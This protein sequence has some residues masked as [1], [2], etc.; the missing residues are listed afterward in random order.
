MGKIAELV[1]KHSNY[2]K[3]TLNLIPSENIMTPSSRHL[4]CSDLVHRY[5]NPHNVYGGTKYSDAIVEET[6]KIAQKIFKS[7]FAFVEPLSGNI[8]VL[9]AIYA[10]TNIGD[11]VMI[12]SPDDGGYP[13]NLEKLGRKPVYFPFDKGKMNIDFLKAEKLILKEK[14]K[15]IIFGQSLF[16]FPHPV[17]ELSETAKEVEA[18]V[19]YDGSHVLGL[20][21]GGV[22]QDPLREGAQI[23]LGS[24]HKTFPGPQGGIIVGI[25]ET[26]EQKLWEALGFPLVLVDNPHLHRIAA[27]GATL[28]EYE[29]YGSNYAKQVVKNAKTLA[30][31]LYNGGLNVACAELGF[32]ESHQV[33]LLTDSLEEGRKMYNVLEE[34]GIIVD[35]LVRLGTQEVTMMGMKEEEMRKIASFILDTLARNK[36]LKSIKTEVKNFLKEFT[37]K[38]SNYT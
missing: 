9:A 21:A 16:L 30:E 8:A 14:P 5:V 32:T 20:I 27:L 29:K 6:R 19:V 12:V 26:E 15:L 36:P 31:E 7:K 17:K 2:R 24:T 33:Y 18:T 34:A 3:E 35:A 10:F 4:L 22:F 25:G 13:I 28:E 38:Y 37:S 11:K 23:L 1:K